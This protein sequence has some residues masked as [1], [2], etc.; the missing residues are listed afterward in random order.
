MNSIFRMDE[1][2]KRTTFDA[3]FIL[4]KFKN[5]YFGTA[6]LQSIDLSV[7]FTT[8]S[9]GYYNSEISISLQ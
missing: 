9:N 1:N 3:S 6:V 7:R 5:Y 4:N 2:K 8:S